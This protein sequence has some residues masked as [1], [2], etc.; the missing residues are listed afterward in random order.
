MTPAII[1]FVVVLLIGAPVA[2]VMAISGVA[3]V[4]SLGGERLV[5]IIADRMFAG[6]SGYML[7]A[8][9]YFIFTAELMNQGG[10]TQKLIAF[11]NALFGR[12]R[13]ALSHV[14]VTVSLFFAGLTGA[15]ITDTVAIGKI[16][17]PEMK[18]QGY[19]AEY[20]AAI[21]AC[22]SI[23]GPIIPPSVV[24]V[25][26]ATLLRDISVIDLFA[27]GILPGV[28]MTAAL[29]L[30]SIVLA[31][32][33][34]YPKQAGTPIR[35]AVLAFFSALPAMLVPLIILGGILSGMTT[36]TEASGFA[37]VYA[38]FIGAVF[39]RNLSPKKI[40]NALVTTVKFSGVVF[41]LLATSAVL[42]WF[43][44]RSGIAR[45]AAT[46]IATLSDVPFVQ[47]M[48]VCLLLVVLGTVMDVLPALVV[49][50]PVVVPA[51][52]SLGFDPLHF[53]IVMI[54]TLNI[55]NVT[56]PVGMTLMTAARIAE[57]P[58]ERAILA[59]L[60]FY[61]AFIAVVVLL[62]AFPFLS[63]W[64]PSLLG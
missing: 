39:Y 57:V 46:A 8:V 61:C 18:K 54:V 10:L 47:I 15:A 25:V 63:T 21:T 36:I 53:A 9:P 41:F 20:A 24:M 28:L 48:L 55:A 16:M 14:N 49:I 52:V 51:M 6:V 44:T 50:G 30:T 5:G 62:A 42:G 32:L 29:L 4:Y 43:V 56:P 40:W 59:S 11:N 38:I 35:V 34:G 13:G 33:R 23:I 1:T 7:I 17:I 45:E 3:G 60:P 19:D 58:Y 12:I 22:S 64:I 31:W 27:G 26:Y 2:V 37:A